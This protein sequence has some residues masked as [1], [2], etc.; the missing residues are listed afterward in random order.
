[1]YTQEDVENYDEQRE[2]RQQAPVVEQAVEEANPEIVEEQQVQLQE[3]EDLSMFQQAG[4]KLAELGKAPLNFAID[5]GN[6]LTGGATP[7]GSSEDYRERLAESSGA[8]AM[9]SA[10]MEALE[11]APAQPA[12]LGVKVENLLTGQNRDTPWTELPDY[13]QDKPGAELIYDITEAAIPAIMTSGGSLALRAGEAAL[14][15][16]ISVDKPQDVIA[17]E[18]FADR[19]SELSSLLTG[20]DKEEVK[21]SILDGKGWDSQAFMYTVGFFQSLGLGEVFHR[22]FKYLFKAKPGVDE[23]AK[24][25][26]KPASEVGETV[27]DVKGSIFRPDYDPSEVLDLDSTVPKTARGISEDGFAVEFL[28]EAPTASS[29]YNPAKTPFVEL[30]SVTSRASAQAVTELTQKT[31]KD[32]SSNPG[33]R[34]KIANRAAQWWEQNGSTLYGSSD[35]F[36][37]AFGSKF[38]SPSDD[39]VKIFPAGTDFDN[40]PADLIEKAFKRSS[41]LGSTEGL[42]VLAFVMEDLNSRA[43]TVATEI[44]NLKASNSDY[45][46]AMNRLIDLQNKMGYFLPLKSESGSGGGR[47]LQAIKD[48]PKRLSGQKVEDIR[49]QDII[50]SKTSPPSS[51]FSEMWEAAKKGDPIAKKNLEF[52]VD[53]LSRLPGEETFTGMVQLNKA[54]EQSLKISN[55]EA[56]RK[57]I[58]IG[59]IGQ[60]GVLTRSA[61]GNVINALVLPTGTFAQGGI[62]KGAAQIF[63]MVTSIPGALK[64][65][66]DVYKPG[67]IKASNAYVSRFLKDAKALEDLHQLHLRQLQRAG[68]SNLEIFQEKI[69]H[70]M[71]MLTDFVATNAIY[72]PL[73]G[74]DASTKRVVGTG[75][76]YGEA[77]TDPAV[78]AGGKLSSKVNERV[79]KIFDPK[80]EYNDVL[81]WYALNRE[82]PTGKYSN[83]FDRVLSQYQQF[84]ANSPLGQLITPFIKPTYNLAE[85]LVLMDPVLNATLGKITKRNAAALSGELGPAAQAQAKTVQAAGRLI[86]ASALFGGAFGYIDEDGIRIPANNDQG[87]ISIPIQKLGVPGQLIV[88]YATL[89]G[90]VRDGILNGFELDQYKNVVDVMLQNYAQTPATMGNLF[91]TFGSLANGVATQSGVANLA[92]LPLRAF[93]PAQLRSLLN[94]AQPYE[95][96]GASSD[97]DFIIRTLATIRQ[98]V[99][100]GVGLPTK[101]DELSG[102]P[103]SKVGASGN[104]YWGSVASSIFSETVL[105][106]VPSNNKTVVLPLAGQM[107]DWKAPRDPAGLRALM[108]TIGFEHDKRSGF[109]TLEGVELTPELQSKLQK[110]MGENSY[111]KKN[112]ISYFNGDFKIHWTEYQKHLKDGEKAEAEI[113][114]QRMQDRMRQAYSQA[115]KTVFREFIRTRHPDYSDLPEQWFE[116][117]EKQNPDLTRNPTPVNTDPTPFRDLLQLTGNF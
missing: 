38:L 96:V 99:F 59:Q 98:R 67:N 69:G 48:F 50:D 19:V 20:A 2:Q 46:A 29:I 28:R 70:S 42:D 85:S 7:L 73:S 91:S 49:A 110:I 108:N 79:A 44:I 60:V 10:G 14:D 105:P 114:F 34:K 80:S 76:A 72:K 102:K 109:N 31:V 117:Q 100:G 56:R 23:A 81:N 65:F 43:K 75:I 41:R 116:L 21:E 47:F 22:G 16:G 58:S 74:L 64:E 113:Y 95:T 53:I 90:A 15:T 78:K 107:I 104:T 89:G 18:F 57:L 82:L 27:M 39:A 3:E 94:I 92:A 26:N 111:V 87:S 37:R 45:S 33:V 71:R 63:G 83:G 88:T 61:L 77:I 93:T 101:Y 66:A 17:P 55:R 30:G 9:L 106:T 54:L 52:S 8:G 11:D 32:L 25:L 24:A 13:L 36:Y 40:A 6:F 51:G 68:A 97:D 5:A 62:K 1:M 4:N 112:L 35:E 86:G 84:S 115:K 12:K 103:I